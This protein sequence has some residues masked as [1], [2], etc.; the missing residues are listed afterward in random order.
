MNLIDRLESMHWAEVETR[1]PEL[2]MNVASRRGRH[3]GG[4]FA[5]IS[6]S[7]TRS[8]GIAFDFKEALSFER[9]RAAC[10]VCNGQANSIFRKWAMAANLRVP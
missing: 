10:P 5:F 4:A 9:D 8:S 7:F 6:C 2:P 1:P 3:C